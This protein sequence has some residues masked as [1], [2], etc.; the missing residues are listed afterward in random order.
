MAVTSRPG[1]LELKGVRLP[2]SLP[3]QWSASRAIA[4]QMSGELAIDRTRFDVGSGEWSAGDPIGTEVR[5]SFDVIL[6]RQ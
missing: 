1:H 4:Q 2:V 6:E 3:F 5:V